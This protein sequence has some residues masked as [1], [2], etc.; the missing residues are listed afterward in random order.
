MPD[1]AARPVIP[2]EPGLKPV[3]LAALRQRFKGEINRMTGGAMARLLGD[4]P[5]AA[6][7]AFPFAYL[8]GFH[9]LRR[10]VPEAYRA[11]V[12]ASFQSPARVFLMNL[13][14]HGEDA[15]GFLRGYIEHW[16]R[17]PPGNPLQQ[18]QLTALLNA[19]HGDPERLLDWMLETW[20]AL[21]LDY[22]PY[23]QA[24]A[25]LAR[26]ERERYQGLLGP[27]DQARLALLDGLPDPGPASE[28]FQKLGLIPAM[29]CPQTCRHCM[30]IW[31]PPMRHTPDPG[32]LLQQ[33]AGRTESVL[34][35]GGDLTRQLADFHRA[36]V[37]MRP[38][39][40]FAILLNGD[41]AEDPKTTQRILN[42]M[43]QA[44]RRRPKGWPPAQ[45]LLQIS[46]DEFHQE[47]IHDPKR[48]LR[49]RIPV[50][51][52]ANIVESAPKFPEI[53]LC[54]L[55]KQNALNFS[56]EVFQ[57]GV[58]ARLAQEL[59]RRG[60]Q[61]QVLSAAPAPRH[62][63]NPLKP[64]QLGQ[65]VKDASF[66][67]AKHP[68]RPILLT[69]STIDAYGR[70]ELIDPAEAVQERDLLAAYLEQGRPVAPGE[71]FDTDLMFWYNGWATLFSAVH[72]GLGDSSQDGL[73]II[74]ARRRKDPL[75][76]ALRIFDPRL[77][78]A[79]AEM[80]NDL[81]QIIASA[82]SPHHLFHCI[83]EDPAVRLGITRW[84]LA[85]G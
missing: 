50:R 71:G 48:G 77:L 74:L 34:F 46:F 14:L 85:H 84:L 10:N 15:R 16:R 76:A 59:G 12:L 19:Q 26:R 29:G 62:K 69:S 67:L 44:V 83:T 61:V 47:V 7:L 70:A 75:T 64:E 39:R 55:H 36:I 82:S 63:R 23:D 3:F 32:E 80:R 4:H 24:Y 11:E 68:K 78:Q 49:E 21:G 5:A 17:P 58:F 40:T 51:K 81:P 60:H 27:E 42:E 79:Y 31:R 66:I 28:R 9:W 72:I 41:F 45:V 38:V 2:P 6:E 33:V 25:E 20:D 1:T 13:L 22:S 65:V 56:M 53:Q 57:Q 30:F 37:E 8:H 73:E 35:T 43:A 54:L 52:I 18:Q